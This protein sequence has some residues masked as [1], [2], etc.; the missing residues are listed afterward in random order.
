MNEP[1]EIT[2]AEFAE[3]ATLAHQIYDAFAELPATDPRLATASFV[4]VLM[5]D[6]GRARLAVHVENM[7]NRFLFP[8]EHQDYV[9]GTDTDFTEPARA[10]RHQLL[11]QLGART[12]ELPAG[13]R[14]RLDT[15]VWLI[16]ERSTDFRVIPDWRPGVRV[17]G[18]PG[19]R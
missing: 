17:I 12:R 5:H 9:R 13:L 1:H 16:S 2:T 19:I 15:D 3:L 4:V 7:A 6:I 8:P 11:S 14:D 18:P 10:L